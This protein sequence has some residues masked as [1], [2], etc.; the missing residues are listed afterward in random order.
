MGGKGSGGNGAMPKEKRELIKAD[1]IAG[2]GLA[3]VGVNHS[4]SN[5]TVQR[6]RA[7]I[8]DQVPQWKRRTVAAVMEATG[9]I[10]D[11]INREADTKTASL[12]DLSISAGI[13]LDKQ[14][15]LSGE[16]PRI[17]TIEHRHSIEAPKVDGWIGSQTAPKTAEVVEIGGKVDKGTGF[18]NLD[19]DQEPGRKPA[20][21]TSDPQ[22]IGGGGGG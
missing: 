2:K 20:P 3:E 19:S 12:K 11:R 15:Q 18:E 1:L 4:V 7:E 21:S 13:L 10:V 16:S 22:T 8:A 17:G 9:K 5:S 6:V 14:Q